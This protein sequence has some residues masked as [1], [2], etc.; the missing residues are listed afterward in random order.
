MEL[1]YTLNAST[2]AGKSVVVFEDLYLD[3]VKVATHADITDAGQTVTFVEPDKPMISTM[4]TVDD[5]QIAMPVGD[6]T[7]TD[8]I[9]YYQL[10]P[11]KEYTLTGV[12]M[13]QA[14][15]KPLT[16][17]GKQVTSEVT[18]T[19]TESSGT[20]EVTFTFPADTLANTKVVVYE[21]LYL[22]GKEVATH[23]DIN[24]KCQTIT[25]AI[26]PPLGLPPPWTAKR[27]PNPARS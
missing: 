2:L 9:S 11:G 27:P 19:P 15:E 23:T 20:V 24:N 17:D 8:I 10:T 16:I 26:L 6:I 22:D 4:A 14:T 25:L 21:Y 18:F 5:E 3:G 7:L 12:L 1:S 13:D